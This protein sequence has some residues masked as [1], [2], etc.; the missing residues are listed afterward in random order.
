MHNSIN[1]LMQDFFGNLMPPCGHKHPLQFN[2]EFNVKKGQHNSDL[3]KQLS[4]CQLKVTLVVFTSHCLVFFIGKWGLPTNA[5]HQHLNYLSYQY[6]SACVYVGHSFLSIVTAGLCSR[7][8]R[9]MV[10][11]DDVCSRSI[12]NNREF[13]GQQFRPQ[14]DCCQLVWVCRGFFCFF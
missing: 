14:F 11:W 2:N 6:V 4:Q 8:V 13:M 10:Q 7:V 5:T 12:L 9:R 1:R 3:E